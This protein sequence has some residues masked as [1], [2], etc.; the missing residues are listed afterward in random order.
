[1]NAV[2]MGI[3]ICSEMLLS[4]ISSDEFAQNNSFLKLKYL[5]EGFFLGNG[6]CLFAY[7]SSE[8]KFSR[9]ICT[10]S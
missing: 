10:T 8:L 9:K 3:K 6:P 5:C 4:T 1:M 7:C 2:Q